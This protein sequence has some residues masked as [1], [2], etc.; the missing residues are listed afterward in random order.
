MRGVFVNI[1]IN[2]LDGMPGGGPLLIT[3]AVENEKLVVKFADTG[4][5]MTGEMRERIFEPF[6][7]TKGAKGHGLGLAVTYGIIERH[8]GDI[9]VISEPGAG[10]TFT[11]S[12]NRA[13]APERDPINARQDG[14]S[15]PASI[16]VV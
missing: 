13:P 4:S 7:T 9:D 3:A 14:D 2:A 5:G 15:R 8:G 6:Y 12:L 16:L 10:T 11:I 1:I